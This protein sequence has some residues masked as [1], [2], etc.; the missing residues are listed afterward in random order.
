[1]REGV[2]RRASGELF[3]VCAFDVAEGGN[4]RCRHVCGWSIQRPLGGSRWLLAPCR[5]RDDAPSDGRR[6][7]ACRA[8]PIPLLYRGRQLGGTRS[9]RSVD[10]IRTVSSS[11][12]G[13]STIVKRAEPR[14]LSTDDPGALVA[15]EL[16]AAGNARGGVARRA[17]PTVLVLLAMTGLQVSVA[18]LSVYLLAG[19][20]AYVTGES[21][22]S[23][24]QKDAQIYLLDYAEN[25]REGDYLKLMDALA[26]PIADRRAREEL[27]KPRP[28]LAVARDAFIQGGNHPDDVAVLIDLFRWFA[29][30]PLMA[31]AIATWTEGDAVIEQIRQLVERTRTS[32][33]AGETDADAMRQ[34]RAEAPALNR[35]LTELEREFSAQ[36]GQASRQTQQ[37]LLL[38]NGSLAI[39]LATFGVVFVLRAQRRQ[40]ATEDEVLRRQESLQLLL[41]SV[42]EGLFGVDVG[43]RCTFINR[44]ALKMLG[45]DRE[46]ELLGRLLPAEIA[47]SGTGG[48]EHLEAEVVQHSDADIYQRRDGSHFPVERWSHPIMHGGVVQGSVTTFFDTSERLRLRRELRREQILME[49]LVGTVTDAVITFGEDRR[50]RVFNA[51]AE[52]LFGMPA[53]QAL[54]EPVDGLFAIPL[55]KAVSTEQA[56]ALHEVDARRADGSTLRL[57][58]SFSRLQADDVTLETVVLRDISAREAAMNERRVRETLEATNLA[59]TQFLS[60]MSH[61][62]R[63]PLNAVIG[64]AQ[65]M[66]ADPSLHPG[67]PQLERIRHIERAGA[68][69]LAL[70]NDVLDLSR[71]ESGEM[72]VRTE[73]VELSEIAEESTML[74]SPLV[75]RNGIELIVSS[76]PEGARPWVQADAVRLRQVL[77]NLLSNAVKYNRSGGQVTL[78]WSLVDAGTRWVVAV[79]DDGP[80]MSQEKLARLFEPFNRLGAEVSKVE[81]TGIGLVLSRRLAQMMGGE[82]HVVSEVGRGTVASVVLP[83]AAPMERAAEVQPRPSRQGLHAGRLDVLYAEDNEVNAEIV[84]QILAP[85]EDMRL[86]IAQSGTVAL[87]MVRSRMPDVLLVDMNLGDMTG[88][89]LVRTLRSIPGSG[90]VSLIALSA[91][92]LPEQI[93]M[94]LRHGFQEYLTKPIDFRKLLDVLDDHLH[95]G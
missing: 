26:I 42:A 14:H 89:D 51:A 74:V 20:R 53:T 81:G 75:T 28:D 25:H 32:V 55:P 41:D 92:A 94:A 24:G 95:V 9:S 62:L 1:V 60:R 22:Y 30:T 64:F 91:D 84:K 16:S 83:R 18:G 69:L 5:R 21:L 49:R 68:H 52:R 87:E 3:P 66:R 73:P 33:I 36:L 39:A 46:G 10:S 76:A 35:R 48:A 82:L 54:G 78:S 4:F 85:R 13:A 61:E 58:A 19:V 2:G 90:Q 43:G 67:S 57:E 45:Y 6:V 65:L 23:K 11:R 56:G 37:L 71:I 93:D 44:A 88:I 15:T 86:R 63:T 40:A 12:S 80:G 17:W 29:D 77:V 79:A 7:A 38:L 59:K 31:P 72:V 34:I 8:A 50:I 47:A 27:Q 70:V